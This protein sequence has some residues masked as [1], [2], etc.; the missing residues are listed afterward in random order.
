MSGTQRTTIAASADPTARARPRCQPS[1]TSCASTIRIAIRLAYI[2]SA[3]HSTY[4]IQA[5]RGRSPS[6]IETKAKKDP[7]TSATRRA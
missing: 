2:A 5:A 6:K 4:P 1:T 7:V 3:V